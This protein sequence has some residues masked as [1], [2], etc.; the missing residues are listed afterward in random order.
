[1]ASFSVTPTSKLQ[2]TVIAGDL[3]YSFCYHMNF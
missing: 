1:M 2:K 3:E